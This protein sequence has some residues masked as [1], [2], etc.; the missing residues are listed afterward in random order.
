MA[1]FNEFSVAATGEC[2]T[3]LVVKESGLPLYILVRYRQ[4]PVYTHSRATH[5]I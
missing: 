1:N 3:M 4:T 5:K 2:L